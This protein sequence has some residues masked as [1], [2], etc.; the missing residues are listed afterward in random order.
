MERENYCN[1]ALD[2]FTK[3]VSENDKYIITVET[4]ESSFN[5]Y[6]F[7]QKGKINPG[8]NEELGG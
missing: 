5:F 8:L 1:M 4:K 3:K 6:L 7:M 2:G